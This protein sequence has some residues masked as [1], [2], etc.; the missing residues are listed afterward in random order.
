LIAEFAAK[1][2]LK[3]S[4]PLRFK[5][6]RKG[7]DIRVEYVTPNASR[8]AADCVKIQQDAGR[9]LFLLVQ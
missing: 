2:D 4:F 1:E 7:V 9:Y 5:A 8:W 3:P 6:M